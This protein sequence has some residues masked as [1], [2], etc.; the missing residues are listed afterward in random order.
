MTLKSKMSKKPFKDR[1]EYQ[2]R[3]EEA[4]RIK[5]K[6]PDRIPVI[7]EVG[8]GVPPM[9]R[10]KYLVPKDLTAAQFMYTLRKKIDLDAHTALYM[11]FNDTLA[12]SSAMMGPIYQD[13]H[14][15]D[16]FLYAHLCVENT[17]G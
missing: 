12:P 4:R 2:E 11:F 5:Q 7:V 13:H 16:Q 8:T 15:E 6:Y 3:C 1:F 17:F 10:Q 9:E 14:D